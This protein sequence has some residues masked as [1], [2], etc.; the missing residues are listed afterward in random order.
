MNTLDPSGLPLLAILGYAAC[1]IFVLVLLSKWIRYIPNTRVGIVVRS[2]QP[3]KVNESTGLCEASAA[4]P[5][6]WGNTIEPDVADW[7]CYRY[8]TQI[9]VVP[10]RNVIFGIQS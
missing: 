7:K 10:L 4:K 6:L 2:P 1:A 8:R 3:E 5:Q 9:V